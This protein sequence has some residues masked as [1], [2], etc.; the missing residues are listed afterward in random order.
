MYQL[1]P[2]SP[3]SEIDKSGEPF[4]SRNAQKSS[5]FLPLI[6]CSIPMMVTEVQL[7]DRMSNYKIYT[8]VLPP[9][10]AVQYNVD[11]ELWK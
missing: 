8:Q 6:D 2:G 7:C 1:V 3:V 10:E 5:I 11:M 4:C 9:V